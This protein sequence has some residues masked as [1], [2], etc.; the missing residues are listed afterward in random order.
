M[1]ERTRDEAVMEPADVANHR[2]REKLLN[3]LISV[4]PRRQSGKLYPQGI[5]ENFSSK[6]RRIE[7]HQEVLVKAA[8]WHI[9]L[10]KNTCRGIS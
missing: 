4:T 1:D 9:L 7:N 10:V 3:S 6:E 2:W 8:R 5:G